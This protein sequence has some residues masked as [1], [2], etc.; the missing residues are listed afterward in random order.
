MIEDF[1]FN[2]EKHEYYF[3]DRLIKSVNQYIDKIFP[4]NSY[5]RDPEIPAKVGE[6]IHLACKMMDEGTLETATLNEEYF[7][8]LVGW[9]NWKVAF[10]QAV[11][12][13]KITQMFIDQEPGFF[14]HTF[15]YAGTP[16]RVYVTDTHI[17]IIDIKTGRETKERNKRSGLQLFGYG[18]LI[19]DNLDSDKKKVITLRTVYLPG[20]NS[21]QERPYPYSALSFRIFYGLVNLARYL[22]DVKI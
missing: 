10:N 4:Y 9:K 14:H 20:N 19:E 15:E 11:P 5:G 1:R 7:P 2:K 22:G 21:F 8:Y 16:D 13:S 12:I 18:G 3:K 17:H 6:H